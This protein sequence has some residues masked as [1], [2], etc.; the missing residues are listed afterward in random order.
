[1]NT[2]RSEAL[3]SPNAIFLSVGDRA[4]GVRCHSCGCKTP[5]AADDGT[6]ATSPTAKI[7]HRCVWCGHRAIYELGAIM[8]FTIK[9]PRMT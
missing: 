9:K 3:S 1:M 2:P 5:I 8:S 4:L 6:F 7:V